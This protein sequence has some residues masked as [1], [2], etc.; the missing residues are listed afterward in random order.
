MIKRLHESLEFPNGWWKGALA[1]AA[2]TVLLLGCGGEGKTPEAKGA[3]QGV[4]ESNEPAE[5]SFYA[6][7]TSMTKPLFDEKIGKPV[8]QK[9]P[10]YTVQYIAPNS[11]IS[12]LIATGTVP[13]IYWLT[14]TE[15]RSTLLQYR[16]QSDISDLIAKNKYDLSRFDPA[17]VQTIKNVS[18]DGKL[19]G[20][21]DSF[22]PIVLFYNKDIFDRFGVPYPVNGMTWDAVYELSRKMTRTES[23]VSYRG[24]G[25][26]YRLVFNGNQLS[27]PL[28]DTVSAKPLASA[29][30]GW[31]RILDNVKRFYEIEGNL[32]GFKPGTDGGNSDLNAFLTEN[33]MAML[34]SPL[35]SYNRD[36]FQKVN[37]DMV[38]APTFADM[39]QTG[40][41]AEPRIYFISGGKNREQA[42]KAVAHLLSDEVQVKN[43]KEGQLTSL[44]DT[45]VRKT[46]GQQTAALSGKNTSAVYFNQFAPTPA[47]N[48]AVSTD[49]ATILAR[50]F[51]DVIIGKQD[52]N[53]ALRN[54][55]EKV[56]KAIEEEAAK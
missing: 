49:P 24:M 20:L 35:S 11:K 12:D 38:S 40:F 37:W 55:D 36:G 54:T 42:F 2:I 27:L 28:I 26:F 14:L 34:M 53:T 13:D 23:G 30:P 48:S 39:P 7:S 10:H 16:L 31:K 8:Q 56:K 43:N 25:M 15:M 45:E 32:S 21:P 33:T 9:Y 4:A 41:Q 51:N 46:F 44:K 17:A 29:T 3:D 5:L 1:S 18:G 6:A 47:L 52:V 19:F 22:N 50:E